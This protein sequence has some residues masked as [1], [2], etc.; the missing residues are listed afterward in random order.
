MISSAQFT[1]TEYEGKRLGGP[2]EIR[3]V[4]ISLPTCLRDA[5]RFAAALSYARGAYVKVASNTAE[6]SYC[7]W[8]YAGRLWKS[9]HVSPVREGA[10]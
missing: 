5:S 2:E 10:I 3:P 6:E 8:W 1:I 9:V 7:E 4:Y